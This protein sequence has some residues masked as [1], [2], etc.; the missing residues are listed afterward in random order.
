MSDRA[1]RAADRIRSEISMVTVL[2]DYGFQVD[3]RG[4]DREQ[5]FSCS[6]HG[7]GNDSIPSG[8][9][10]PK[11]GQY[12]CWACGRSRDAVQVTRE[13]E[14]IKFWEAV[15]KLEKRYGLP[16]LPWE[17]GEDESTPSLSQILDEV[18]H[19][20]ETPEQALHRVDTFL[21][22]L[23]RERAIEPMKVAAL[24]EAYDRVC[25]LSKEGGEPEAV[26]GM[27]HKV[28]KAS[29][30]AVFKAQQLGA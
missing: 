29:K 1:K 2:A 24:W 30:E 26:K 21:M 25:A 14:G 23:C 4:G 12:Y 10:Y 18:L 3:T 16:M 13:K 15:R 19:P 7:D 8:R 5:Q 9:V 11:S 17:P 6:L 28:L 20:S 27:A 22:G